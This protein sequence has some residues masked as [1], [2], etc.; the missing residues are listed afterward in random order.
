MSPKLFLSFKCC[1]ITQPHTLFS[2]KISFNIC[3][4]T[5]SR[6]RNYQSCLSAGRIFSSSPHEI[7]ITSRGSSSSYYC[8]YVTRAVLLKQG[9]FSI[10]YF[11]TKLPPRQNPSSQ[12]GINFLFLLWLRYG[13][14]MNCYISYCGLL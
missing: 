10:R 6:S 13:V 14:V 8:L 3:L 9:S 12:T 11:V 1:L 2:L 5:A 4:C 7:F